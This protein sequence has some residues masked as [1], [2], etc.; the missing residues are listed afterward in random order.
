MESLKVNWLNSCPRCN[1]E[2][3][4]NV[5]SNSANP[6]FL[7]E[8]DVVTCGRCKLGGVIELVE[9]GIVECFWAEDYGY[10]CQCD[11][12]KCGNWFT[13]S[14]IGTN[15]QECKEGSMQPQDVEPY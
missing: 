7:N 6:D 15:C 3:P 11:N 8:G 4:H 12:P 13:V 9:V 1:Y 5:E 14:K 2:G 10:Y